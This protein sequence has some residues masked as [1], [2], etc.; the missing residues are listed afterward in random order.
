[1]SHPDSNEK[2]PG[3]TYDAKV[4][5]RVYLTLLAFAA[6]MV[7]ISR[8]PLEALP[9]EWI[10]LH[11]LKGLIILGLS[12][13]MTAVVAGYLMG[14]KYESSKLNTLLF[15][16]NFAFLALFA[17]FTWADVRYRGLID[18]SFE[19]QINWESPVIKAN[20]AA[21]ENAAGDDDD[22][23]YDDEDDYDYDYEDE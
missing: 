1:M 19:K 5:L 16:S 12:V 13:A 22:Y 6:A 14:L 15:L 9:I 21:K 23:D 2:L 4:L 18:P 10:D 7:A 20:E 11:V 17:V 3:H 8:L